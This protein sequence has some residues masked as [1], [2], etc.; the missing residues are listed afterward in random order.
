MVWFSYR[1]TFCLPQ[2]NKDV[3]KQQQVLLQSLLII[4][5]LGILSLLAMHPFMTGALPLSADGTLHL[6]RLVALDHAVADGTLWPR[7]VPGLIFGYGTPMFNY[8][9]PLSIY[10]MLGLHLLGMTYLQA[11]LWGMMLYTLIAAGGAYLLGRAW[12]GV[13]A[14]IVTAAAYLYAPYS[15]FDSV[16][17][18]TVSEY[19]SLALLPYLLWAIKRL[20]DQGR[21]RDFLLTVA[22]FAVFFPM[23]NVISLHGAAVIGLY[24]LVLVAFNPRS[25]FRVGLGLGLGLAVTAFFWLPAITETGYVRLDAI[26]ANLPEIDVTRNLGGLED[27]LSLPVQADPTQMQPPTPVTLSW[28]QIGLAALTLLFVFRRGADLR[29]R[30]LVVVSL[31]LMAF[32]IFMNLR[33]SAFFWR[34]IPL[35]RY[36][37]FPWRLVGLASLL[38][39]LLTGLGVAWVLPTLKRWR[40]R[41]IFAAVVI[42]G[43]MLYSVPWLYS[44]YRPEVNPQNISDSLTFERTS[45]FIGT[46]SFTEYVPVWTFELPDPERLIARFEQ[47][48]I[49]PRLDPPEGVTVNAAQWR[50]TSAILTLNAAETTPLVFDWLYFPGWQAWLNGQ[51][52]DVGYTETFGLVT[53]TIPAG[54]HRLEIALMPTDRQQLAQFLSL[55]AV[56]VTLALLAVKPLFARGPASVETESVVDRRVVWAMVGTAAIVFALKITVIDQINTPLKHE[57]FASGDA[58]GVQNV[59]QT[60]F[61]G[62]IQLIGYDMPQSIVPSGGALPLRLYWR[63]LGDPL[64]VDYSTVLTLRSAQGVEMSQWQSW[65]PAGL[66]TSNWVRDA[67]LQQAV[68]FAIPAGTPPGVY[69]LDVSLYDPVQQVSLNV[70]NAAGNPENVK[71][72]LSF[73]VSRP[74]APISIDAIPVDVAV[75]ADS[76]GARLVGVNALPEAYSVGQPFALSMLWQVGTVPT[77]EPR[78]RLVWQRG[79]ERIETLP[80][81]AVAGFPRANWQDGDV[82]YSVQ[83]VFV[84]GDLRGGEYT[85]SVN[86]DAID[87]PLGTMSI[88]APERVFEAPE[89]LQPVDARWLNGISLLGAVRDGQTVT[90]YW[91]TDTPI[92]QDLRVFVHALGEGEQIIAQADRV[93]ADWV[94]PVAGWAVGEVIAD[95]YTLDAPEDAPLRIG[96]YDPFTLARLDRDGGG[97]TL[98]IMLE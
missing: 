46:S 69:T 39:A 47:S 95:V 76:D 70:I 71:I 77:G 75:G 25:I 26:T 28:I 59:T 68:D 40:V 33:E 41:A 32:L 72:S 4:G 66:T 65:Q 51:P 82:W 48:D 29:L 86:V 90:L 93:P 50:H 64:T 1:I 5:M 31:L 92:A 21:R 18:G 11:W 84:P 73:E 44:L 49:I 60:N 80:L 61:D 9:S 96:W 7:Y 37:Q 24:T 35:I 2:Y 6:Y 36:S 19:A 83:Q 85:V 67:Y 63:L 98:E 12:G 55:A 27:V 88:T 58:A 43:V 3:M 42:V 52:L 54:E 17:R 16:A 8:Y 81:P 94:R 22:I 23:H 79:D 91:T 38:L 45:D 14:G 87:Y 53:V 89:D 97:D 13:A 34:V 56:M 20:V 15:L 78:V 57:R 74:D 10:P 30:A 62:Q